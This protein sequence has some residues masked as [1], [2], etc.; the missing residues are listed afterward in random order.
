M[1]SK[2]KLLR[3]SKKDISK[4]FFFAKDTN[5]F[6]KILYHMLQGLQMCN[7]QKT[8]EQMEKGF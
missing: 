1:M 2:S 6:K 4:A 5:V 7:L 8:L 3:V